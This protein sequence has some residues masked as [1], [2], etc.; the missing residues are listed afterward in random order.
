MIGSRSHDSVKLGEQSSFGWMMVIM[1]LF[2]T[3]S[4]K[5]NDLLNKDVKVSFLL[6]VLVWLIIV[7]VTNRVN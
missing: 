7:I 1:S 2:S 6:A 4:L 5:L 3:L